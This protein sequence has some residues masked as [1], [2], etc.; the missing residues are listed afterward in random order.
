MKIHIKGQIKGGKNNMKITRTGR[1][2]PDAKWQT[3][4]DSKLYEIKQQLKKLND[5]DMIT[6]PTTVV[7]D[8]ISGDNRRRDVPAI[9]DSIWHLLEKSCVVSDDALLGGNG[10]GVVF[11]FLGV[12]K[13]EAG[14]TIE[15]L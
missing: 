9:L 11:K 2:Y 10:K 15:F 14:V 4:R 12:D 3:W 8:Y 13:K 6:E 7:I 1:H 5:F